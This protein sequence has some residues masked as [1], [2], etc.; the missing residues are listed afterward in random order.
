MTGGTLDG[1]CQLER[2][3]PAEDVGAG[4]RYC[5]PQFSEKTG[6]VISSDIL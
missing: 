4:V 6:C 3:H 5:E 1:G 2:L